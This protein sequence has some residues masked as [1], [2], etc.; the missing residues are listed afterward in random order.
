MNMGQ[1]S[2]YF[3]N[4]ST[5][6]ITLIALVVFLV[7]MVVVLPQ[8][9]KKAEASSQG[10]DSPDTS[11]TYSVEALYT[12]AEKYGEDGRQA[13]IQA[14]FSFDILF[15]LVYTAFLVTSISW[16]FQRAFT[17]HSGWQLANLA[18]VFG[19]VFDLAENI[20]T[21]VVMA[22]YPARTPVL[23]GLAPIFTLVKWVFV[24]GSFVFLLVGILIAAWIWAR[25]KTRSN[26]AGT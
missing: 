7:F 8:Q 14:R 10:A 3:Y 23:D 4:I 25:S 16:V 6:R 12:M 2:R 9:A 26:T 18:P 21:S 11:F 5:G 22:R 20:S 13:Y 15:P 17:R 19:M 1:I 24:S